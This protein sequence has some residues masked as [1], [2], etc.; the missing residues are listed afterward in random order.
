MKPRIKLAL[1][2]YDRHGPLLE[3]A[4]DHPLFDF[5]FLEVDPRQGRH[6]R[7]LQHFEFDA[8]ELSFSSYVVAIDQGVP[9]HAVPIFPRRLFSQSQ[10]YKNLKSG[11]ASPK[12]LAGKRIGL[13]S[14]Q[15]TLGVRAKGDLNHTYGVP[16]KSVTW[17]VAGEDVV[18]VELPKDV[19][20]ERAQNVAE[21]E[22]EFVKGTIHALFVSRIP[23][24]VLD[25]DPNVARF[26]ADPAVEEERYLREEGYFPIM[27]VLA[28]KQE[29]SARYPELP[30]ALFQ[31]F[32]QARRKALQRWNDPNWSMLLWGRR[33]FERQERLCNFDAWQNG[34]EPNRKNIERFAL[35][36]YEQGLSRRQWKPE[37]LFVPISDTTKN[38]APP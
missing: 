34:L 5:E 21:I 11:I 16:W 2:S 18:R 32:E 3:N 23:R 10:M 17:V 31:L 37:E 20:L 19:K 35:Y 7:F 15:N 4:I 38:L 33:E 30:A 9:V 14:Y 22:D 1:G 29:L 13:S 28:F 12:D 26:F 27:H 8:C 25:G 24:P 36:S 6:E